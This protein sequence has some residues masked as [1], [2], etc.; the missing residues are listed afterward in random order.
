MGGIAAVSSINDNVCFVSGMESV[1][2]GERSTEP[3][4]YAQSEY[5]AVPVDETVEAP[6]VFLAWDAVNFLSNW[7]GGVRV[8]KDDGLNNRYIDVGFPVVIQSGTRVTKEVTVEMREYDNV[9]HPREALV[10]RWRLSKYALGQYVF[11]ASFS[12]GSEKN[13]KYKVF[14]SGAN[15]EGSFWKFDFRVPTS[16]AF[17][18]IELL[19][20]PGEERPRFVLRST[21]KDTKWGTWQR[22]SKDEFTVVGSYKG[23]KLCDSHRGMWLADSVFGDGWCRFWKLEGVID[24]LLFKLFLQR[25]KY[26]LGA[27]LD[28]KDPVKKLVRA[29]EIVDQ[30]LVTPYTARC[31]GAD[32]DNGVCWKPSDLEEM[33]S[34][35]LRYQEGLY[36]ELDSK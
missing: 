7:K 8:Y 15:P 26:Q 24:N 11:L 2:A 34:E 17:N 19:Q 18:I 33:K 28:E 6:P 22:F 12:F 9:K 27:V 36:L 16:T 30:L 4:L 14:R 3:V 25:F 21:E 23:K 10:F 5:V 20:F 31:S 29:A 13:V 1:S 35:A 32:D